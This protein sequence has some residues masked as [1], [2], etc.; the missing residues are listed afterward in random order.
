MTSR[1]V[2]S[3]PSSTLCILMDFPIYVET[4]N[5]GR[6]LCTKGDSR[7]NFINQN[8]FLSPKVV[9]IIE[10]SVEPDEMQHYA[11]FHLG[12]YCL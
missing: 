6:P 9:L 3:I 1:Y 7:K 5:M 2:K 4:I 10:N 11:A 8:A 12:P